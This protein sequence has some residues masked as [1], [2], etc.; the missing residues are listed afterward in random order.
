[1]STTFRRLKKQLVRGTAVTGLTVAVAAAGSVA[2]AAAYASD[3][4]LGKY[5]VAIAF[6]D[7]FVQINQANTFDLTF[8]NKSGTTNYLLER[9][10]VTMTG[11][12]VTSASASGGWTA[13]V[14]GSTVTINPPLV[15]GLLDNQ[16][17]SVAIVAQAPVALV[18]VNTIKTTASGLVGLTG[19]LT[20]FD[21]VGNDPTVVVAP[22]ATTDSC[23]S[24][25]ECDTGTV[26]DPTDTEARAVSGASASP[27]TV[28]VAVGEPEGPCGARLKDQGKSKAVTVDSVATDRTVTVTIWL[29]KS[30]V[31][32]VAP[33]GVGTASVCHESPKLFTNKY[34]KR[35]KNGILADCGS[36]PVLPCLESLTKTGAGDFK[37]TILQKGGD[38][39]NVMGY[40]VPGGGFDDPAITV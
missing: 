28:G 31:N 33:N 30:K 18:G 15:V 35:V 5:A 23:L 2:P 3:V 1:M 22:F 36:S 11:F 16:S 24:G 26:G 19:V 27:D 4:P 8:T 21:R 25:E 12:A 29:D 17:V 38:P 20:D 7:K 32:E 37:A 14:S 34:G 39:K 9:A 13:A 10:T 6:Q 40:P